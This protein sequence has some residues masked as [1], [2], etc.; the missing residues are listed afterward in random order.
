MGETLSLFRPSFNKPLRIESRPERPI[1]QPGAVV[2]RAIMDRTRFI[3][4][5]VDRVDDT[6]QSDRVIYPLAD[7]LRTS[8]LLLGRGWRDQDGAAAALWRGLIRRGAIQTLFQQIEHC[9]EPFRDRFFAPKIPIGVMCDL[10]PR[11]RG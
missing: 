4:W 8:L 5:M 2:L 6:R 7:L 3:E 9:R 1:G 10:A 11:K